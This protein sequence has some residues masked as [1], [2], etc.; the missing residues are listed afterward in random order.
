MEDHGNSEGQ[1][2]AGKMEQKKMEKKKHSAFCLMKNDLNVI[3]HRILYKAMFKIIV[4]LF[5]GLFLC[6][7]VFVFVSVS[8]F[9]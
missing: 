9:L 3:I 2:E 4:C 6:V 1:G 7:S 5:D 8:P